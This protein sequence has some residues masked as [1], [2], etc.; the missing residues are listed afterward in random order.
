MEMMWRNRNLPP[1]TSKKH[2]TEETRFHLSYL[3]S[4]DQRDECKE[5]ASVETQR[6]SRVVCGHICQYSVHPSFPRQ[7]RKSLARLDTGLPA[8]GH[9]PGF[10]SGLMPIK[11]TGKLTVIGEQLR[12]RSRRHF[13][14]EFA[15]PIAVWFPGQCY[16]VTSQLFQVPAYYTRSSWESNRLGVSSK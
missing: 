15:G 4:G 14:P 5:R 10:V 11:A 9:D 8:T 1:P 13:V 3:L 6:G 12:C 7:Y 16:C 2:S